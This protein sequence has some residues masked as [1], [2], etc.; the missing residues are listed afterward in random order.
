M[1][2]VPMKDA[3]DGTRRP[4]VGSLTTTV[5][6][7]ISISSEITANGSAQNFAHG[8]GV[9]PSKVVVVPTDTSPATAGVFTVTEGTHTATNAVV[10]VTSGK[11][12][13]VMAFV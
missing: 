10:T 3:A 7:L 4:D 9:V 11:K 13:K 1:E 6:K 12:Y 8:L 2:R 5:Q